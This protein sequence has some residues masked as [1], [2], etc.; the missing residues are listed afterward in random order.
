M[1]SPKPFWLKKYYPISYLFNYQYYYDKSYTPI[2]ILWEHEAGLFPS[3]WKRS[4]V[5]Y[6]TKTLHFLFLL[7]DG[8]IALPWST[9][10]RIKV[11]L[12]WSTKM[13]SDRDDKYT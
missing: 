11:A 7:F 1:I 10:K 6:Y 5:N 13:W 3:V 2:T 12:P 4:F 8:D 9:Q